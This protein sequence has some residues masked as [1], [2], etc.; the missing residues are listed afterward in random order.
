MRLPSGAHREPHSSGA[1]AQLNWLRAA[2]LGAGDG[3]ISVASIIV[4]VAGAIADLRTILIGGVAG[5]LAGVFSMAAGEYVS[6]SSQRDTEK[7]LL[8]KERGEL[9]DFPD[10][11]L[12]E[13]TGLYE[14]KGLTRATASAVA[15]ELTLH[16]VFA[17]H[18]EA[19]LKIDPK[20]LTNPW[21]AALAS[22]LSF[23]A[24]GII[25]LISIA[26]PPEPLRVPVTFGAV[27]V[28]LV[29]TGVLS[30]WASG[31]SP[32]KAAM[33][34]VLGGMLAM[35][36]TYGIGKLFGVAGI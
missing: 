11:E 34:V 16:D 15:R 35:V 27:F 18:A 2:V 6:V 32:I 28:A 31:A 5:L 23:T 12:E 19:E 30:A 26:L 20:E 3:I 7:A 29:I 22:A 14:Q 9:R 1:A 33:R 17:A 36:V 8:E 4:G 21:H 25:P 10:A 24:G 13:L